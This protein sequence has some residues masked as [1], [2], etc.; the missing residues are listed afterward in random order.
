M[1]TIKNLI[2]GLFLL[3]LATTGDAKQP[4][5]VFL[6]TDD[7][8]FDSFGTLGN[9]DVK[10][11]HMD[12]L[13]DQGTLFTQAY[14]QGSMVPMTCLPSRAMIM[15][16]KSVFRAP[17]QLDSGLLLPQALR[18]GGYRT[19]STG[20]WHNGRESFLSCFGE[21]EGVFF[22]GAAGSHVN[23]PLNYL[24]GTELVPYQVP[25]VH[26]SVLFADATIAYLRDQ[27]NEE[28][29]FFCYVPFTAPHSPHTPPGEFATMYDPEQLTL[30]P[31]HPAV[32]NGITSSPQSRGRNRDPK[33]SLA[34]YYGMVSHL[35]QQIGRILEAIDT[36]G[37]RDDTIILFATDHGYSLGSH[38]ERGKANGY[39]H[40]SR[41]IISFTGPGIPKGKRTP[42][43]AYLLDIYPTL[44]DLAQIPIP[45]DPEGMSLA[46][47]IHGERNQVRDT[48]FTAFM[49]DQ[50][51][52]RNARWKL[53]SRLNGGGLELFDLVSDPH[54]LHDLSNDSRNAPIIKQLQ[55]KLELARLA[56]GDSP[57]R[58][59]EM[60]RS[61]RGRRGSRSRG[62]GPAGRTPAREEGRARFQP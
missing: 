56:A 10:T 14:I 37:H 49:A 60:L 21:A 33:A 17:M 54:E 39:E 55:A 40:G 28:Q 22:G 15:S 26:A 5:I 36:F 58:V 59:S 57:E 44:C 11:P 19:F 38:G 51:T 30:P 41:S 52:I 1:K 29:P 48:L 24:E 8:R 2:V 3:S 7:Q 31:N 35:D 23:V 46:S 27:Q 12:R 9:P 50:R 25:G 18:K 43:F 42:A 45:S 13:I 62:N 32:N 34:A 47:V 53:F 20:K 6:F 16:G 4:N 61:Q